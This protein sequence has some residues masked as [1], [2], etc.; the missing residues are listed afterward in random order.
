M[1][2]YILIPVPTVPV[3]VF[4]PHSQYAHPIFGLFQLT[5]VL[6]IAILLLV[7]GLVTYILM[8]Y[9]PRPGRTPEINYGNRKL[10]VLW[11]A[12]PL[13][14]LLF[15]FVMTVRTVRASDPEK[16][17]GDADIVVVGHQ[18]WWEIRYPKL[19]IVTANE[20]HIPIKHGQ[21]LQ[22]EA[23]DVIHDFWVPQLTRKEDMNPGWK[24]YIWIGA[25]HPGTYLGACAEYCGAEHAWMRIRV[26]AESDDRFEQWAQRQKQIPSAP[27]SYDAAQGAKLFRERTC[28]NCHAIAGTSASALIGPDLTHICSRETLAAGAVQNTPDNLAR[29]V[30][31]PSQYKPASNMPDLQLSDQDVRQLT[32]Y[33]ETLR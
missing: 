13:V 7:T 12:A 21:V 26:I 17:A 29:W 10:E 14:L 28:A 27:S 23:A 16:P 31:H 25:D 20:L 2:C 5:L 32:A 6:M 8:R 4:D 15:L 19:N 9:R 24:N 1:C 3:S 18:W 33:L 22:L 11:T 30:H